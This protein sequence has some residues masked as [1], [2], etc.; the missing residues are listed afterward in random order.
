MS[1]QQDSNNLMMASELVSLLN[2]IILLRGDKP[3]L[4]SIRRKENEVVISNIKNI[5][6]S[7]VSFGN[8]TDN[9]DSCYILK[10]T[11]MATNS[12]DDISVI[13]ITDIYEEE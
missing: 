6:L 9:S 4:M 3:V 11:F 13:A 10:N 7:Q 12:E 2:N 5:V 1:N 8:K